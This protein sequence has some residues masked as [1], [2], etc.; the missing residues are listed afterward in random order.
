MSYASDS[1]DD[2]L[3]VEH[4]SYEDCPLSS[5]CEESDDNDSHEILQSSLGDD[6]VPSVENSFVQ[7]YMA[8]LLDN[9]F[10]E[11]L[12]MKLDEHGHLNDFMMLLKLLQS[13]E[14]PMD[15]IV[16][17][18]LLERIR[19]QKC[20]NTVGMRYSDRTKLF[21]TVVYQLCKG[22]GLKF[23]SGPKNWGQVVNNECDKSHYNPSTANLNF[24][25]P[26]EKIL[27]DCRN[28]IPKLVPPGK[29]VKYLD[30]LCNKK[31]IVL[32][33]DGKLG[34]KGLKE[35][36]L[37][38]VNLF[39][40]ETSPNLAELKLTL[41]SHITYIGR[42]SRSFKECNFAD[43]YEILLELL[44]MN[45]QLLSKICA[46][47][48]AQR[49]KLSNFTTRDASSNIPDKAIS[50]CKTEI[51]TS[52][53]WIRNALKQNL[54][55]CK[56]MASHQN[57]LHFFST[58]EQENFSNLQNSRF[59][60]DS[61]YV[62]QHINSREYPN[63]IK[64]YSDEWYKLVKECYVTS[65]RVLSALGLNG[66]NAMKMHFKQFVKDEATEEF[67]SKKCYSQSDI[68]SL[69][70]INCIVTPSILPSCAIFYEE[71]CAFLDGNN[72]INMLCSTHTG[73][74]R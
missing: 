19:F 21:W 62:C 12:L 56:M 74:I 25:V 14:F 61:A 5:T 63:L 29:I 42:C 31:D 68:N 64:K 49:K 35:S 20:Q 70:T 34:T 15:N 1:D 9:N 46:H 52:N 26:D 16:F 6:S 55:I 73:I 4:D 32:M 50:A 39:G 53:M 18:L 41:E 37:G 57:N 43:Q 10:L 60:Y 22:S 54:E 48:S 40:H 69:I 11:S 30:M 8:E 23:F 44:Q 7:Q 38:N 24:T 36:F 59:L 2:C 17:I 3:D 13:G 58:V 72:K 27:R 33:A 65:D 28:G 47:N 51:Y 71:G 66:V 67:A 45:T